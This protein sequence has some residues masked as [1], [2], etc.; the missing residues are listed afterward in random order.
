MLVNFSAVVKDFLIKPF[1]CKMHNIA[2]SVS[3]MPLSN[4]CLYQMFSC[5]CALLAY[6]C[7]TQTSDSPS[8]FSFNGVQLLQLAVQSFAVNIMH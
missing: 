4:V 8:F 3:L 2:T 5:L 1:R 7:Y 6:Y